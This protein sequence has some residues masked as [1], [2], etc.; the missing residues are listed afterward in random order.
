MSH[1]LQW[2]F[3][4]R[5]S[6][7]GW[8]GRR[9]IDGYV[10]TYIEV[11]VGLRTGLDVS[12]VP[13]LKQGRLSRMKW[14]HNHDSSRTTTE[15]AEE[16]RE[17]GG[18]GGDAGDAGDAPLYSAFSSTAKIAITAVA[19]LSGFTSPLTACIYY[20]VLGAIAADLGVSIS[21]ANLTVTSFM[22]FQAVAPTLIGDFGDSVGRRPAFAVAFLIYLV[23]NIGLA[24]QRDYVALLLLRCVQSLGS[25]G[26]VVLGIATAADLSSSAERGRYV[27]IVMSGAT[28]GP[29]IGPFLGGILA[30]YLGWPSI[31]WFCAI[32]AV[33]VL[34]PLSATMPETCRNVVGNGSWPPQTWNRPAS[35]WLQPALDPHG[36]PPSTSTKLRLP[37]PLSALKVIFDKEMA[38]LLFYASI[39]YVSFIVVAATLGTQLGPVYGLNDF[40]VGLCYLPYGVGC[41]ASAIAQGFVLDRNYSRMARQLGLA[42]DRKRGNDLTNF[43]IETA[44]LQLVYPLVAVG[45]VA[46]AGYG[47]A[48]QAAAHMAIS[49]VLL[50][51]V[52]GCVSGAF[53]ILST[54]I[55]DLHPKAPATATAANNLVRCLMGAAGTASV[56]S[57]MQGMGTGWCFTFL[58]ALCAVFTP[59]MLVLERYGPGWRAAKA[60]VSH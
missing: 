53:V 15:G 54:L 1:R 37:N 59:S 48:L 26:T 17:D 12:S 39:L 36:P 52:G 5:I 18:G 41:L 32:L 35:R 8:V 27:G 51:L 16:N 49:L 11:G 40:Q 34:V 45:L 31:F 20:P 56:E 46:L 43:P 14:S 50:F 24:L 23:A 21:H 13:V 30:Q 9:T 28:I 38:V 22:V 2:G 57:M 33:L 3:F 58:A 42:V 7:P 6:A 47:W 4:G 25:S 10:R 55:V 19:T 44:R 29:A 60:E